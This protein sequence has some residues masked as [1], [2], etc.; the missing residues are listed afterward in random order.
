ML[1]FCDMLF[2]IISATKGFNLTT[3]HF[4][5]PDL[6]VNRSGAVITYNDDDSTLNRIFALH[7]CT[8]K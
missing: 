3:F 7:G 5:V 2:V 6:S 4:N 1:S 8:T